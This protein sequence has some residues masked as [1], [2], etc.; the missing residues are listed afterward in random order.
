MTTVAVYGSLID[1]QQRQKQPNLS[2]NAYPVLV[3]GYK[4]VFNQEPSWRKGCGE[5]RAVLNVVRSD[6]DC[7]NGLLVKL[8]DNSVFLE[9]DK[10]EKG[11]DRIR[12]ASSQIAKLP[13]VAGSAHASVYSKLA[14]EQVYLYLGKLEKQNNNISPNPDYL[15]LC[16]RGAQ[17]WG[18][19][20]YEQFLQTTYVGKLTLKTFLESSIQTSK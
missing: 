3:K 15:N 8:R 20:F 10:R 19:R 1:Q 6:Q 2:S 4:R 13:D 7:F 11:Y 17:Q 18:D 9:L 5:R 14:Q 16:L 12:V